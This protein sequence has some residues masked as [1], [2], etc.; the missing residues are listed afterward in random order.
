MF[1]VQ[2]TL[3]RGQGAFAK[4]FEAVVSRGFEVI[5]AVVVPSDDDTKLR[6]T[7]VLRGAWRSESLARR[8]EA[9]FD[10]QMPA[11]ATG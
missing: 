8:L 10:A 11:V 4:V 5:R 6:A 7:L 3:P 9:L 2:L 1:T